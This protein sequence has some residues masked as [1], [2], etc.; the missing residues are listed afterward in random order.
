MNNENK[1]T[2]EE[3]LKAVIEAQVKGGFKKWENG[4]RDHWEMEIFGESCSV[5]W[6]D[7]FCGYAQKIDEADWIDGAR[8]HILEILLDTNG[9]KAA[10]KGINYDVC[11]KCL[12][13]KNKKCKLCN[14]EVTYNPRPMWCHVAECVFRNWHSEKGNNWRA[15][16]ETA[17]NLLPPK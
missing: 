5:V 9:L 12:K 7:E 11:Y 13:K 15:A 16:L 2:A 8:A 6:S 4:L 1:L 17:F 3:I 10:Y 14:G